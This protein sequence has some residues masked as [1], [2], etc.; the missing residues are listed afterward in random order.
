M[1]QVLTISIIILVL[2]SLG[3]LVYFTPKSSSTEVIEMTSQQFKYTPSEIT[4]KYGTKV[5][6]KIT[7]LDVSHGFQLEE[8]GIYNVQ[9]PVGQTVSIT[10]TANQR[11]TFKF[12]CTV[13]CGVG[14]S[15]HF[16]HLTVV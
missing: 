9:T 4:V 6:L 11:G 15:D 3:A 5:T 12:Y 1:K 13:I 10:F 14:H 16:G 8:F 2:G 7:A